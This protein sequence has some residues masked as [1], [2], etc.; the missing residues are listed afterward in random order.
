[1]STKNEI[2]AAKTV[3]LPQDKHGKKAS[4]TAVT[5]MQ[6]RAS[7]AKQISAY[8]AGRYVTMAEVHDIKNNYHP[9]ITGL[10]TGVVKVA[11][12][13]YY[14]IIDYDRKILYIECEKRPE[15]VKNE[16]LHP[17][18]SVLD[19]M[20]RNDWKYLLDLCTENATELNAEIIG[21]LIVNYNRQNAPAQESK[22]NKKPTAKQ[23]K[24]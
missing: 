13:P 19:Y 14:Q 2:S 11:H 8:M 17:N 23:K 24:K 9:S 18:F 3:Q 5:P 7:A 4:F 6:K 12:A 16:D 20:R 15:V 22:D 1:M 21:S 10:L